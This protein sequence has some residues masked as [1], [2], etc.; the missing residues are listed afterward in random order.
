MKMILLTKRQ[1]KKIAILSKL[2]VK[3]DIEKVQKDLNS[4][5]NFV[6][7]CQKVDT[8]GVSPMLSTIESAQPLREDIPAKSINIS[9]VT[10]NNPRF[11]NGNFIVP[12]SMKNK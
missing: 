7:H 9:S 6:R 3:E 11:V 5:V 12:S 4:V 10:E 8:A 1:L 2:H